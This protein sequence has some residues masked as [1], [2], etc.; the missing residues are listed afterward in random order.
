MI[1][2]LKSRE[3]IDFLRREGKVVSVGCS[4][5]GE[6]QHFAEASKG[7]L[8]VQS[9]W[10]DDY[11]DEHLVVDHPRPISRDAYEQRKIFY[12]EETK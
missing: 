9:I 4:D 10:Y 1:V 2:F 6:M 11:G 12:R 7:P 8:H 5:S 3:E